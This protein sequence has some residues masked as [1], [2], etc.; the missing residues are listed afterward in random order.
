MCFWHMLFSFGADCSGRLLEQVIQLR[1]QDRAFWWV[2]G[3]G[4]SVGFMGRVLR[5][6]RWMGALYSICG[7][8]LGQG[9]RWRA[10]SY[11]VYVAG[12]NTILELCVAK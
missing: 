4:C 5:C 3:S 2:S 12:S 10:L 8:V 6:F 9:F 1:F 7:G 11:I